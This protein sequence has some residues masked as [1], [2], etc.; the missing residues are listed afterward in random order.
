MLMELFQTAVAR[1]RADTCL[2]AFLPP[3]P[4]DGRLIILGAGKAAAD[5]ARVAEHH[6][7]QQMGDRFERATTG[8]VVTRYGH[9]AATRHI[10][11]AEAS[12]PNPDEAGLKATQRILALAEGA[13]KND[14]VLVLLSGGGSA[15]LTLPKPGITLE[16]KR[17]TVRSLM[18]QGANILELN[19][20]R[21]ALSSIK[22]GKLAM[23]AA[24]A[25]TVTLAISDVPAD[26]PSII[27]SGPTVIDPAPPLKAKEILA[28]Y[29]V[30]IPSVLEN[31]DNDLTAQERL[32]GNEYH[33][34]AT[35]AAALEAAKSHAETLGYQVQILGDSLEGEAC[36]LAEKQADLALATAP[37]GQGTILLSGG[38]V[39]VTAKDGVLGQGGPNQEYALALALALDGRKNIYALSCD[40]DGNDGGSGLADDPAGALIDPDTLHR[41]RIDGVDPSDALI[42]HDSGGFFHS[43]GDLVRTGPT[44]TNVNDF[45]AIL[46]LPETKAE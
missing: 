5:M 37:R 14:L 23:A 8:L 40:T 32:P 16:E 38:E 42:K 11:I 39:T 30:P 46:C 41:A 27:A 18:Q 22:G 31:E 29:E 20:V 35:P 24:P 34:I 4:S 15:L 7:S 43:T 12:H 2:A 3:A 26:D 44:F 45:R 33:L 19:T 28:K 36:L 21:K 1:V 9:G 25:K 17:R 6:Y 10:E 13:T